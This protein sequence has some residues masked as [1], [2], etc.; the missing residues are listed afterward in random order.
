M[1]NKSLLHGAP[2][3][4]DPIGLLKAC[5]MRIEQRCALLDRILEHLAKVG[6][7]VQ[8][9]HACTQVLHYFD[10]SGQQHHA[11][12]EEDLFPLLLEAVPT[13]QRE[14]ILQVVDELNSDHE[15]M[16]EAYAALRT[17]LLALREGTTEQ[18]DP[19]VVARFQ[20]LYRDHI[21]REEREAFAVAATCLSA[22]ELERVGRAMAQRRNVAYPDS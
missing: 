6:P 3:F 8:V 18:L 22:A 21:E 13:G 15:R 7:D 19:E 14:R 10:T 9:Q 4:D 1:L 12:E 11:D 20:Q 16:A 2:G 5:H 17:N